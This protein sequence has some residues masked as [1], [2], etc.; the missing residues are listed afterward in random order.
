MKMRSKR[1]I[2]IG[3]VAL[4]LVLALIGIVVSHELREPPLE[5]LHEALTALE[6]AR[7]A[8]Q[9]KKSKKMYDKAQH[10]L[11]EGQSELSA[12]NASWWPFRTYEQA[13]SLLAESIRLSYNAIRQYN[14]SQ[15]VDISR[16]G[17]QIKQLKANINTWQTTLKQSLPR[18]EES[19]LLKRAVRNMEISE[20]MFKNQQYIPAE[21]YADSVSKI[22]NRLNDKHNQYVVKSEQW[23]KAGVTWADLTV[24]KSISGKS[25]ALIVDKKKH[26][27]Y[28]LKS[29][30]IIDSMFCDLGFNTG[31]QKLQSGDGA[32]P[33]GMYIVNK[34]NNYSKYYRAL[35][36]NYPNDEDRKRFNNNRT[37]GLI[38]VNAKIGSLIEIHGHGGTG[39]DWTDGCVAVNDR[40]MD[41]LMKIAKVGTPVTIV[42][43]WKN[44]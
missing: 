43:E 41:E 35:L 1:K 44:R 36:L 14:D 20:Q 6:S 29:G 11:A 39:K 21:G 10:L 42:R 4:L 31:H 26:F 25:Y 30:R 37:S 16:V 8:Q 28:L 2:I 40:E 17:D 24:K 15:Q 7:S 3:T 32:T 19:S 5:K 34:V 22:L 12:V 38:S 18:V 9:G 23:I 27:M 33:E 13:D